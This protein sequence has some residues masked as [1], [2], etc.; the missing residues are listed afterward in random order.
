MSR[1]RE[2]ADLVRYLAEHEIPLEMCPASNC[3]TRVVSDFSLHP[4]REYFDKGLVVSVNTDD[5]KMFQTSLAEE[6]RQLEH[7]CCFTKPEI[8][9]LIL[10]AIKS[11][12][13]P[14]ERKASLASEF[15]KNSNWR[16][17]S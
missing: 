14:D 4:I 9:R 7:I 8:C 3:L 6:F 13:L 16:E 11:S 17:E 2:D 15:K 5:P 12:W 1:A 10:S